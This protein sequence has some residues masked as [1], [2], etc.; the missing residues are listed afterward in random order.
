MR[1]VVLEQGDAPLDGPAAEGVITRAML[2]RAQALVVV[3]SLRGVLPARL[4]P[5]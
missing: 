4:K 5:A 2:A 1:A 3:N